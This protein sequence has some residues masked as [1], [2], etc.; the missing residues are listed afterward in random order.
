MKLGAHIGIGRGLAWTASEAIRLRCE[1][2]QIFLSNPRGWAPSPADDERVLDEW[3]RALEAHNITPVMGHSSYL[4]NLASPVPEL[5]RKSL[6]SAAAAMRRGLALGADRFII[7]GGYHKGMGEARSRRALA[8]GLRELS[9]IAGGAMRLLLENTTGAG[10]G[11]NSRFEDMAASL[12]EAGDE[13]NLGICLDTCHVHVAGYD[14]SSADS[15]NRVV[16]DFDRIVGLARLGAMHLNDAKYPVGSRRDAHTH[17]GKGTIGRAGFRALM[18]DP[19]LAQ[20]PGVIETP[21]EDG[22]DARN[23]GLLRRM[24]SRSEGGSPKASP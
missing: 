9:Q 18:R 17:I 4:V 19:R 13:P 14:M 11:M 7:P 2:I 23:L 1:C 12:A 21:K 6:E 3:R 22:W 5:W 8:R 24:R 16:D 15:V 10:S 20:M